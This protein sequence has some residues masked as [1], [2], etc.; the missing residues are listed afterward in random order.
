MKHLVALLLAILGFGGYVFT[1]DLQLAVASEPHANVITLDGTIDP[2]SARF[3]ARAIDTAGETGAVLVIVLL[4]TPGGLLDSTREMVET[5][6]GSNIPVIVYVFP[7][8]A[9]AASA[10]TFVTAAAHIAAMAPA[11]NI[12]AASPVGGGGEDLPE[13]LKSKATQDAAA[14]MRSIAEERGRNPQALEDT[15]ISAASFSATEAL[16]KGIVDIIA[17]DLDELLTQLDGLT[18]RLRGEEVVLDTE[19]LDLQATEPTPVERF[20]GFLANPN[21]AFLLLTIGGIG[22]LV[23]FLNPGMIFPAVAG[24]I[25]LALA[26]V[27]VGNLPVNWAGVAL[28]GLA[29]AL[30]FFELQAPGT[31]VFGGGGAIAFVLGA[32]LLFGEIR[33]PPIP[34]PSFRVS[35]WAI[36]PV[37]GTLFVFLI[38]LFRAILQARRVRYSGARGTIVGQTGSARSDIDPKGTVQVAG[39]LWSAISDS[40]EPIRKGEEVMVLEVEGL[41]LKVFKSAEA[42][43]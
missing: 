30:F 21:V 39:E 23:E 19:G 38:L 10:G 29:M 7:S 28:I 37:S 1:Q 20:L 2:I 18:V 8:G 13:T 32:F 22:I 12:G 27:A 17:T 4:D 11:T 9:Q 40:G 42:K 25:A 14:F 15:V 26:F 34:T 41:R 16:D 31:G 6:Q 36:G 35:F 3:L 24:V 5:I 43:E 33:P